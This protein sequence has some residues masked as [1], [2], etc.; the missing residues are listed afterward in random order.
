[1]VPTA[2]RITAV[3]AT[4]VAMSACARA[5]SPSHVDPNYRGRLDDDTLV[6]ASSTVL[7]TNKPVVIAIRCSTVAAAL[8]SGNDAA[9]DQAV[10]AGVAARI[11]SGVTLYSP[12]F[13]AGN[14]ADA[15]LIVTDDKHA[16]T[17]CTPHSFD[18]V[19]N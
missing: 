17:L 15:P 18:V 2:L 14:P 16:G 8:A 9:V 3:V 7:V 6:E 1:M 19:K 5:T 4:F 10:A 11:P 12:P 13:S